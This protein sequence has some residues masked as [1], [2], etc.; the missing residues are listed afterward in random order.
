MLLLRNRK[1]SP[2]RK[3][4][5]SA[6]LA[7]PRR[8]GI[9]ARSAPRPPVPKRYISGGPFRNLSADRQKAHCFRY[10]KHISI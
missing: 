8:F 4:S 1:I 5:L 7:L 3:F 6:R 9:H 2:A 10:K